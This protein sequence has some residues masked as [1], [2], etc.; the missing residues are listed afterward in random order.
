MK[1]VYLPV[2]ASGIAILTS[3][4][5]DPK[6]RL[7]ALGPE[8]LAD[9]FIELSRSNTEV[10][11][12]L[13]RLTDTPDDAIKRFKAKVSGLK[14]SRKFVMWR[15][16]SEMAAELR[17]LLHDL[18]ASV[19]DSCRGM[20]LALAF[21]ETDAATF[22]R[23]DD[24]SGMIGDVYRYD[25]IELFVNYAKQCPEKNRI[26]EEVLRVCRNDGFGIR[27][28]LIDRAAEYLQSSPVL[29][30]MIERLQSS[31]RE[32]SDEYEKD[33]VLYC[34]KSLARQTGDAVLFEQ[35]TRQTGGGESIAA[36]I[37]IA[38]VWLEN[39]NAELALEKLS[40]AVGRNGY[41]EHEK[42]EL[43]IAIHG[44]LGNRQEQADLCWK[45]F[46]QSRSL[47][48]LDRF[49][50]VSDP[51]EKQAIIAREKALIL[52]D[53]G[54]SETDADFLIE[55][56]ETDAAERYLISHIDAV[57]GDYYGPLLDIAKKMEKLHCLPGASVLYR[58]LLLS[59]LKRAKS[60]NYSHGIRYLHKL[61]SLAL[62]I[63]DWK[64]LE[65]HDLFRQKLQVQH[66]LKWSFW[67]KYRPVAGT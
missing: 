7:I 32:A 42:T 65:S 62:K 31:A 9:A 24:S 29:H 64:G 51:R 35:V 66:K 55:V 5:N 39:G 6:A 14:R 23:C 36:C 4:K 60:T 46:R 12:L 58:A 61:D 54:F 18:E 53:P 48:V 47:T 40:A 52:D 38:R 11:N 33:H 17:S 59:I 63:T 41:M 30:C 50:D 56:G 10:R 2:I 16:S 28:L 25:A 20:E 19:K 3:M 49:L 15:E 26:M 21:M 13:D 8:V 67:A 22:G 27:A 43:L 44:S 34:V 1:P 37:D 45:L 57:D